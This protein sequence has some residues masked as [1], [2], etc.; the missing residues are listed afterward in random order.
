MS[1]LSQSSRNRTFSETQGPIVEARE[2]L[3][4]RENMARRKEKNGEKSPWG[5]WLT[6][7]VPNGRRRS[8]FWLGRKT[9]KFSGTNQK[10]ERRRNRTPFAIYPG[11]WGPFSKYLI[12]NKPCLRFDNAPETYK[13][14][15]IR[16]SRRFA[17]RWRGFAAKHK[18]RQWLLVSVRKKYPL[19][20][21]V[22]AIGDRVVTRLH[23]SDVY[24]D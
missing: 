17:P 3:N 22:L 8:A 21:R 14:I 1:P 2:S 23:F 16:L 24:I 10:A 12:W 20:P 6:R 13:G 4:G 15:G 7:P 5:Q 9:Q 18:Y 11:S 19:E